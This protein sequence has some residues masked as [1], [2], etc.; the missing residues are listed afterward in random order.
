MGRYREQPIPTLLCS[1]CF[2]HFFGRLLKQLY[3][4][5]LPIR[6]TVTVTV[7][8]TVSELAL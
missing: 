8:V 5:V 4:F 6:V 1:I 7:M 2:G 3:E